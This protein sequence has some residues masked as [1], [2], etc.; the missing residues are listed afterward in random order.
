MSTRYSIGPSPP[1]ADNIRDLRARAVAMGLPSGEVVDIY[2]DGRVYAHMMKMD[3]EDGEGYGALMAKAGTA[4][5]YWRRDDGGDDAEPFMFFPVYEDG[6]V[7]K[8]VDLRTDAYGM[9]LPKLMN[10]LMLGDGELHMAITIDSDGL[11]EL[12][13]IPSFLRAED[14]RRWARGWVMDRPWV[15]ANLEAD[16]K[17]VPTVSHVTMVRRSPVPL[18]MALRSS[19][20]EVIYGYDGDWRILNEDG[21]LGKRTM[22]GRHIV[23]K[24]DIADPV[25]GGYTRLEHNPPPRAQ[26]RE[27]TDDEVKADEE[28]RERRRAERRQLIEMAKED[29]ASIP[30]LVKAVR[31]DIGVLGLDPAIVQ[32]VMIEEAKGLLGRYETP[33]AGGDIPDGPPLGEYAR[34]LEM[35]MLRRS[36]LSDD[37]AAAKL[38]ELDARRAE[39]QTAT[40]KERLSKKER[41]KQRRAERAER[42]ADELKQQR[43]K[44]KE[45]MEM[46]MRMK[47]QEKKEEKKKEEQAQAQVQAQVQTPATPQSPDGHSQ[48]ADRVREA[49]D[50]LYLMNEMA[51]AYF[52]AVGLNDIVT[53]PAWTER[54]GLTAD[55]EELKDAMAGVLEILG[56]RY[57]DMFMSAS[58]DMARE[59]KG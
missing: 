5:V 36:G 37:E 47:K 18:G 21:S 1:Y 11:G 43:T 42:K 26:G 54:M 41:A 38:A 3:E 50:R 14:L 20:D 17:Y 55:A 51:H 9:V 46:K 19:D 32:T 53:D 12:G 8:E 16:E 59:A 40:P 6:S 28:A 22:E 2:A 35:R 44:E 45:E 49:G 27:M 4:Y 7:G 24:K 29:E 31:D 13:S 30:G 34:E 52:R 57:D 15:Y 48:S 58:M 33:R 25:R 23:I 39:M 56:G 10:T